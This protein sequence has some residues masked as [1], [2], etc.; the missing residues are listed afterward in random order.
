MEVEGQE[1]G[2]GEYWGGGCR[3]GMFSWKDLLQYADLAQ[4]EMRVL[5]ELV[6]TLN[7]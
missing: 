1:T 7:V 4:A 5:R 2:V 6:G 3:Q